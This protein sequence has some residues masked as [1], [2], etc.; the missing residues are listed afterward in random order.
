MRRSSVDFPHPDGPTTDRNWLRGIVSVT[1]FNAGTGSPST[2]EKIL[3]TAWNSIISEFNGWAEEIACRR[4]GLDQEKDRV[5]ATR[6][7][8]STSIGG[9]RGRTYHTRTVLSPD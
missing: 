5:F 8:S 1:S 7:Q 6:P 3:S 2:V 4:T 9:A